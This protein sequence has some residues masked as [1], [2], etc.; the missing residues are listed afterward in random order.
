[1]DSVYYILIPLLAAIAA[2]GVTLIV[3]RSRKKIK[4]LN[5]PASVEV[6]QGPRGPRFR[7]PAPALRELAASLRT[8]RNSPLG[9]VCYVGSVELY[10]TNDPKDPQ[11]RGRIALPRKAWNI[12]A[13]K[14]TEVATGWEESPFDFGDCGYLYPRPETDLGVELVGEPE[15]DE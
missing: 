8:L 1:M 7:G 9:L 5:L 3:E 10:V 15:K 6:V 13:S 12:L 14:F 11:C 4:R 2:A